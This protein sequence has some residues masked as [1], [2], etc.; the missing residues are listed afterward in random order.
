MAAML[1]S[2]R[3]TGWLI[4]L[5]FGA[6]VACGSDDDD[7]HP[8]AGGHGGTSNAAG[9][10]GSAGT[11]TG[12][13]S[14][15]SGTS[16]TG[17]TFAP[18]PCIP[19]SLDSV[20]QA[21]AAGASGE[22]GASSETPSPDAC[23]A[24]GL[25]D[26]PWLHTEGNQLQAPNGN[27]VILR[28]VGIVDLGATSQEEGGIEAAIDRVTA[29][30][31]WQSN[32]PGW[33][34]HV[35][36][37]MVAPPDGDY[38]SPLPY[39][40]DSEVDYYG[41]V[42]R[43]AVEYARRKG[44]YAIIDWHQIDG[45]SAHLDTTDAF[46]ADTAPRFAEDSH[47]LFELFSEPTNGGVWPTTRYDMEQWYATVRKGAPDNV[48]LVGTA[49]WSQ[50]VGDAAADPIDGTNIMYVAHMYP[51]HFAFSFLQ[52]QLRNAASKVP[53]FV[54]EW[55]FQEDPSSDPGSGKT[56]GTLGSY[57][58]PFKI[59]LDE[60]QVSWTA[61]SAS[62]TWQPPMFDEDSTLRVGDG[63]MGGFVKDWL[64]EKRHDG[65]PTP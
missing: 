14:G 62:A 37:L 57:G 32:S 25:A 47:V 36:R 39:D 38:V 7:T 13:T 21:G 16:G 22:A 51:E 55:G 19:G 59:L 30:D 2:L 45:T 1:L 18:D 40:P 54:S 43:P 42:L 49:N 44:L 35:V 23:A 10:G 65:V 15:T 63:E 17:G 58:I 61:W 26:L 64:Y 52:E 9:A 3:G 33:A 41:T 28:G 29:L 12:G 60:L 20:E 6:L 5:T 50:Q 31:D 34:T 53:V 27:P 8:A 11:T 56:N 4:G 48:V 24:G 46:W